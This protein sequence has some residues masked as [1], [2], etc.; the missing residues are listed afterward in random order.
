[1]GMK[2]FTLVLSTIISITS[3]NAQEINTFPI[4]LNGINSNEQQATFYYAIPFNGLDFKRHEFG[5]RIDKKGSQD[6][7]MHIS[8]SLSKAQPA[9]LNFQWSRLGLQQIKLH[10]HDYSPSL[11]ARVE[12]DETD[13]AGTT[14]LDET[15]EDSQQDSDKKNISKPLNISDKTLFGIF[16][17]VIISALALF[18]DSGK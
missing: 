16:F 8:K 14:V 5:F 12:H 3:V 9:T 7:H 1:M 2:I 13:P 6:K 17:G 4:S 11:L 10:G 15:E 18:V